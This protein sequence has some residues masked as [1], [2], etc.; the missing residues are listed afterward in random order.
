MGGNGL[1]PT[2]QNI[3]GR[4]V[5]LLVGAQPVDR[6]HSAERLRTAQGA[7]LLY[8]H[9]LIVDSYCAITV[10]AFIRPRRIPVELS[11]VRF[12][13]IGRGTRSVR[14]I[15]RATRTRHLEYIHT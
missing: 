8:R 1:L 2:A 12:Q 9:R 6:V 13:P 4:V 11:G 10:A 15:S 14:P 5:C 7:T 3:A